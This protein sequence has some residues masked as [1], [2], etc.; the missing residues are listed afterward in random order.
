MIGVR[1]LELV[2]GD[3]F[4]AHTKSAKKRNRQSNSRRLRSRR[5]KA[6]VK[7]SIRELG[8]AASA[9]QADQAADA[10]KKVYKRLDVAAAKG[11]MHKRAAS[12]KKS[13]LA[14]R[15]SRSAVK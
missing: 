11:S 8:D 3:E 7:A 14:K 1:L 10:L 4:V 15:L 6:A 5:R 13:R 2:I 12:R 9:G